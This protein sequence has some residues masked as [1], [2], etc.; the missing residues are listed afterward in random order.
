MP[1]APGEQFQAGRLAG[2]PG[3]L[4]LEETVGSAVLGVLFFPKGSPSRT[5]ACAGPAGDVP[6]VPSGVPAARRALVLLGGSGRPAARRWK[7]LI[8]RK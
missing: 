5:R 3:H 2:A 4:V 7:E 6:S 8:L 1:P